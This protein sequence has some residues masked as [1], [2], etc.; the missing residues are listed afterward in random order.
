MSRTI[1]AAILVTL[2]ARTAAAEPPPAPAPEEKSPGEALGLSIGATALGVGLTY[3]GGKSNSDL[4]IVSGIV[5]TGLGP[6]AGHWYAG[7]H[8][9]WGLA[10]RLVGTGVFA[11]GVSQLD[12]DLGLCFQ[13]EC[14][15]RPPPDNTAAYT[16]MIAGAVLVGGGAIYDIATAPSAADDY[17]ASHAMAVTPTVLRDAHGDATPGL[18]LV[19]RF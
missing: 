11:I 19:G 16:F 5:L 3:V 17:N 15:P 4:T 7:E 1:L 6:T 10:A 12:I 18:A 2:V 9:T 8:F 13:E 14:P